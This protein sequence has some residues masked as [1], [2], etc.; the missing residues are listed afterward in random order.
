M[1]YLAWPPALPDEASRQILS[2]L[3][4]IAS[5]HRYL[6]RLMRLRSGRTY[7]NRLRAMAEN[8]F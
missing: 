3:E 2:L 6:K 5:P 7:S 4:T 8:P 1:G